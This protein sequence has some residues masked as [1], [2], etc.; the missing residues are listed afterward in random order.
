MQSL[1]C[2]VHTLETGLRCG[3]GQCSLCSCPAIKGQG[4]RCEDCGHHYDEHTTKP[5]RHRHDRPA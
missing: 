1:P 5:F 4:N 2:T 3:L